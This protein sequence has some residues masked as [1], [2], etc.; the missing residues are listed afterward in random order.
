MKRILTE[1]TLKLDRDELSLI[2]SALGR[3]ISGRPGYVAQRDLADELLAMYHGA[4][5]KEVRERMERFGQ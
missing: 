5:V 4:T 1:Y 2:N 3:A